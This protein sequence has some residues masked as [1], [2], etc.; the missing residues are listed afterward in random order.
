[1]C[2]MLHYTARV[3]F[4]GTVVEKHFP[5]FNHIWFVSYLHEWHINGTIFDPAPLG[6]WGG[7]KMSNIIRSQLQSRFRRFLNQTVCVFSQ[8]KDIK[9]IRQDFHSVA[10][11]MPQKCDLA[12]PWGGGGV[13]G[14]HFFVAKF[15]QIWCV[16]CLREWHMQRHTFLGP[17][18]LVSWGGDKRPN[19]IKSQIQSPFQRFLNQTMCVFSQMKDIKDIRQDLYS[20]PWVIPQGLGLGGCWGGA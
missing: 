17:R 8:K 11:V 6:P 14:G 5:K 19:I 18:P 2:I 9:H 20:V 13:V 16:N 10:W 12:V 4:G 3:G 7:A 15:N 1:M